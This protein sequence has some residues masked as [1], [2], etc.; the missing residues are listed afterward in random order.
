MNFNGGIGFSPSS[1]PASVSELTILDRLL[2]PDGTTT[3]PSLTWTSTPTMGW[4]K[5]GTT[6]LQ[7]AA[8][9]SFS[10]NIVA[11][12]GIVSA[13]ALNISGD[14][15]VVQ[16][17][18]VGGSLTATDAKLTTQPF[19]ETETITGTLPAADAGPFILVY[20]DY[21][22]ERPVATDVVSWNSNSNSTTIGRSGTY[23]FQWFVQVPAPVGW[24]TYGELQIR[25]DGVLIAKSR[26][27]W[28]SSGNQ[29]PFNLSFPKYYTAGQELL[30]EI[31]FGSGPPSDIDIDSYFR[32]SK[33]A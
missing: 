28:D 7:T 5:T 25:L 30:A 29:V 14:G 3:R 19:V 18:S 32:V 24:A 17:F 1:G 15:A 31:V 6:I 13:G 27:T 2:L 26:Q 33:T 12:S 22:V 4:S 10:G 11:T 8:T 20:D 9:S 16:D 21:A 23:D